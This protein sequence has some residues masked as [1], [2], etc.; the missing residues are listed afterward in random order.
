[1]KQRV[2]TRKQGVCLTAKRLLWFWR[3]SSVL[4][5]WAVVLTATELS[6]TATDVEGWRPS[7]V[8]T[9]LAARA[10]LTDRA[11]L[12]RRSEK[13][14]ANG[15]KRTSLQAAGSSSEVRLNRGHSNGVYSNGVYS[16]GVCSSGVLSNSAEERWRTGRTRPVSRAV[17]SRVPVG[18]RA[19]AAR[20]GAV[21][22]VRPVCRA[23]WSVSSEPLPEL[24]SS[25]GSRSTFSTSSS[26]PE[27]QGRTVEPFYSQ[28][29]L[30]FTAMLLKPLFDEL[31]QLRSVSSDEASG[32]VFRSP[33]I[34]PFQQAKPLPKNP[35][36]KEH[37]EEE[38][39]LQKEERTNGRTELKEPA[40]LNDQLSGEKNEANGL[41][42][43]TSDATN[44]ALNNQLSNEQDSKEQGLEKQQLKTQ[45]SE[46]STAE[47]SKTSNPQSKQTTDS[48]HSTA[49]QKEDGHE[50]KKQDA[51]KPQSAASSKN[52]TSPAR[53]PTGSQK[54]TDSQKPTGSQKDAHKQAKKDSK[55][56]PADYEDWEEEPAGRFQ[57]VVARLEHLYETAVEYAGDWTKR[58][59]IGARSLGGNSDQDSF[60]VRGRLERTLTRGRYAEL[61]FGGDYAQN[62]GDKS[63][64]HWFANGTFDFCHH[65]PDWIFYITT[66]NEFD[67]FRNLNWRGTL[68]VGLGYRFFN[69][70]RKRLVARIGPAVTHEWYFGPTKHRTTPDMFAEV[71]L[72]WPVSDRSDLESKTTLRPSMNDLEIFRLTNDC[73]LLFRLDDTGRWR[74]K[75]GLIVDY[76][77]KPAPDR[78]RTDYTTLFSIIYTRK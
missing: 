8:N 54:A 38:T 40:D 56:R 22:A 73:S 14:Q 28:K 69:E 9:R 4:M 12:Q 70:K 18:E 33:S 20:E 68:S 31:R 76:D 29:P 66:K 71:D 17:F 26:Q 78:V 48:K 45:K 37:W 27:G 52:A 34:I 43:Q 51:S 15:E 6:V 21:G 1:M 19:A 60:D 59:E 47:G 72:K 16:N 74:L 30:T 10:E 57:Q 75:L 32:F 24:F 2:F 64:N 11:W 42:A 23:L 65:K 7:R 50:A 77:S 49:S 35:Q 67:E 5:V 25:S 44:P 61:D 63:A 46:A 55:V 58:L 13:K 39:E 41:N 62:R 3:L 36:P 53:K